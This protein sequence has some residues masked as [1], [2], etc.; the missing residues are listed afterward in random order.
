MEDS[1]REKF[2]KLMDLSGEV[3]GVVFKTDAEFILKNK[4]REG[5]EALEKEMAGLGQPIKYQ[6]IR[7][8]EFYPVGLRVVSLLAI[9]K[10]FNFGAGKIKEMGMFAPKTSL[11]V[12]FFMQYFL[13]LERTL[14]E[15]SRMWRKH[16]TIGNLRPVKLDEKNKIV[17]L[18]LEGAD[19]DRIFCEYLAGY[20]AKVMELI[21][22]E[23]I[24]CEETKCPF[25]GDKIHEFTFT[26]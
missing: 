26:W 2:K 6:D 12:K 23:E 1:L 9:Q 19:I 17:V 18:T 5:L 15:V 16:Y 20:F 24:F 10:C 13:S 3:R 14:Q 8:M 22:R 7:N 25:K 21:I 4:G 11:M